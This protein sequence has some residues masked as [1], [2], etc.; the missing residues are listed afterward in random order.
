MSTLDPAAAARELS[1]LAGTPIDDAA[2]LGTPPDW[3]ASA[4][5]YLSRAI[6]GASGAAT[7]RVSVAALTIVLARLEKME[8][9]SDG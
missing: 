3:L 2:V 7:V 4:R 1:F 9:R 8:G 6:M 5:T